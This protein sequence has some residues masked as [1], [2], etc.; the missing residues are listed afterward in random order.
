MVFES[1]SVYRCFKALWAWYAQRADT[2]IQSP[3]EHLCVVGVLVISFILID[4]THQVVKLAVQ[5][6]L[7]GCYQSGGKAKASQVF[8]L[9]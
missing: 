6:N 7:D 9:Y 3:H 1:S 8:E 5:A 2:L 4:P